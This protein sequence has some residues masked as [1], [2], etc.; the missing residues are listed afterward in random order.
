[1]RND[2]PSPLQARQ[3]TLELSLID[4]YLRSVGHTRRSVVQLGTAAASTLLKAASEYASLRLADMEAKAHYADEIH[5][6]S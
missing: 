1:M 4:D 5:R 2:N 6:S 3:A